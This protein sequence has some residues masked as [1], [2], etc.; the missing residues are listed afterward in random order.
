VERGSVVNRKDPADDDFCNGGFQSR[1]FGPADPRRPAFELHEADVDLIRIIRRNP[2]QDGIDD[3][4][5]RC[6]GDTF[7][8]SNFPSVFPGVPRQCPF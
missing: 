4:R 1:K 7:K 8:K 6:A 3:A 2:N 5:P